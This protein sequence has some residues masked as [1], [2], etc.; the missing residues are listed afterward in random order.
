M[1]C[2]WGW[3]SFI[4]IWYVLEADI[5][6]N[7]AVYILLIFITGNDV[8]SVC[9]WE[10]AFCHVGEIFI[11]R[12]RGLWHVI[13]SVSCFAE[14]KGLIYCYGNVEGNYTI[15]TLFCEEFNMVAVN[16]IHW[17]HRLA[18]IV[19]LYVTFINCCSTVF[20]LSFVIH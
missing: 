11:V 19:D 8:N 17:H 20:P 2:V 15:M 7:K 4:K 1:H 12:F 9:V 13:W 6:R 10:S 14:G 16:Y 3:I 18:V 5:K